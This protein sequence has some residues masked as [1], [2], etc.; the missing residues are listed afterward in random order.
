MSDD[1]PA[2]IAD[3]FKRACGRILLGVLAIY[4]AVA[5]IQSIWPTL[6]I[7]LGVAGVTSLVVAGVIAYRKRRAGW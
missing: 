7:I 4:F 3:S 6:R 2:G 5:L 1:S